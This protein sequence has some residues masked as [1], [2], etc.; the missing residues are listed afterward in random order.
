MNTSFR[1]F[2]LVA[3]MSVGFLGSAPT[4]RSEPTSPCVQAANDVSQAVTKDPKKVLLIVEDALVI[5]ETCACEIVRAAIQSSGADAA[6]VEQIVLTAISVAPSQSAMITECAKMSGQPV[7]QSETTEDE[8]G[9]NPINRNSSGKNP[10][11]KNPSGKNALADASGSGAVNPIMPEVN[12]DGSSNKGGPSL[13]NF[14]GNVRGVYLVY[15]AAGVITTPQ[16][17]DESSDQ[18]CEGSHQKTVS[19]PRSRRTRNIIPL[20]PSE[21]HAG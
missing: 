4:A 13:G 21:A 18:C 19:V 2:T 20:S 16:S 7:A 11:G 8:S 10:S 12:A 14:A 3:S 15:P 17:V 1:A 9:K 6:M 5:N